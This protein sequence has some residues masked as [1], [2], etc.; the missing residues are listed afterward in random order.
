[1]RLLAFAQ[2]EVPTHLA[3][4]SLA[5]QEQAWPATPGDQAAM[6]GGHDMALD[7]VWVLLVEDGTVVASLV[8]LSK[9][10]THRGESFQAS[11]L[12]SVVTDRTRRGQGHGTRLA[13]A[14]RVLVRARGADLGIFTCDRPL[15][16]FYEH[17]GWR[18]LPGTVLVGG[19]SDAPLPSDQFDKVTMACLFTDHARRR[20]GTF[21][22]ARIELY[23]GTIDRLW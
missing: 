15:A 23:P 10:I 4:Q 11:G 3:A 7:P 2:R 21:E 13:T 9:Q 16:G 14:G 12:S 1:M 5:M 19:T 8:I 22:H 20:A 17:A 18:V 6:A